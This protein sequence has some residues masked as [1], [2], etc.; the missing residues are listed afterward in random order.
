MTFAGKI[1][2]FFIYS[3]LFIACCSTIMVYQTCQLLLHDRPVT[4]FAWFVFFATICSYSFHWYI[5]PPD[6]ALYSDRIPWLAKNRHIHLFLFWIGLLGSAV[7]SIFLLEF[8]NWLLLAVFLTFLYSAPKL[9]YT[10]FVWL[11]KV[12]LGKTIFLA[13]VWTYVTKIL[14]LIISGRNW[15]LTFTLFAS[16]RFFF[17]YAICII[18]DYRDREHDRVQGI[19]S[20]I[21]YLSERGINYLFVLSLLAFVILTILMSRHGLSNLSLII[22]LIPGGITAA[23]YTYSQKSSSDFLYFF[24]LDGL[25]AFSAV[26]T[27][28]VGV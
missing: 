17:I 25:M 6:Q 20:L 15:D 4:W 3:N 2:R 10:Y 12:A 26:S 24:I 8:W 11:R 22:L 13:L 19:R 28:L 21:T 9:S 16:G 18:F 23:L 7:S 27:L 5:T 1:F 14:P